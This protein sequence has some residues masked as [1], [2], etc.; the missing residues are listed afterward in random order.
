MKELEETKVKIKQECEHW[1]KIYETGCNDPF[2]PD[3]TNCNLTRNHIIGYKAK[4]AE[5]CETMGIDLPDEY[6]IP[7]PPEVAKNYM[8]N[9][10][11]KDRCQIERIKR[12][13]AHGKLSAKRTKYENTGQMSF[14]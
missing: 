2:W 11:P 3:G 7:T 13:K 4:I 6:Y 8:A 14:I 12:L 5:L 1:Q 9:M 10:H